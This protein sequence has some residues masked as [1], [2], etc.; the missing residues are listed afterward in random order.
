VP[1]TVTGST[2][3]YRHQVISSGKTVHVEIEISDAQV[4]AWHAQLEAEREA[5]LREDATSI[6]SDCESRPSQDGDYLCKECRDLLDYVPPEPVID[7]L[8]KLRL[9]A[10][11]EGYRSA[12]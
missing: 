10:M 6:C 8:E 9:E 4:Y 11:E 2:R 5:R 12:I 3:V 1:F 7:E